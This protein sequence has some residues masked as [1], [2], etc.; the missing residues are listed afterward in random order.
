MASNFTR[1]SFIKF[2]VNDLPRPV[3]NAVLKLYSQTQDGQVDAKEVAD[4]NWTEDSITWDTMPLI[5][6]VIDSGIGEP[7]SWFQIDLSSYVTGNGTYTIALETPVNA[8]GKLSSSEADAN[9]PILEITLS[10]NDPDINGDGNINFEDFD[11]INRYWLT[12]C[13]DPNWCEGADLNISGL[14]D[15]ED[16]KTF[17]QSWDGLP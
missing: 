12:P 14:V 16:V 3:T 9:S 15:F 5:G 11:F 8:L 4:S 6:D 13:L 1:L 7:N 2:D 17:T 10:A